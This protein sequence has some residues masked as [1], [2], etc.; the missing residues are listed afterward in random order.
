MLNIEID[1]KNRIAILQPHGSLSE[2]DFVKVSE[3]IDPCIAENGSLLG[4]IISTKDFPGWESFGALI[5]HIKFV[6]NHHAKVS[7]I[8]IVTDS[9]IGDLGEK[10]T[11]HF[12]SAK[13]KHYPYDQLDDARNWILND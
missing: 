8:A 2:S 10:V 12:L 5:S 6:K 7:K 9:K 11:N 1:N 3:A 13:I 4:L